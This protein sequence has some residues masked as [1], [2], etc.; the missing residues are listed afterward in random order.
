MEPYPHHY[1]HQ[2]RSDDLIDPNVR[3]MFNEL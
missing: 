1:S 2:P 3:F